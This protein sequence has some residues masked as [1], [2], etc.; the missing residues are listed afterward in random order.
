M[1]PRT[2]VPKGAKLE[3]AQSAAGRTSTALDTRT[4]VPADLPV[5]QLDGRS[6]IP[7]HVPLDVLGKRTVVPRDMPLGPLDATSALPQHLP[8]TVLDSRVVVPKGA[9]PPAIAPLQPRAV[10]PIPELFEPDILTTGKINLMP[11]PIE[12]A[13]V[14]LRWAAKISSPLFHAMLIWLLMM[15]PQLFAPRAP[16]QRDIELAHRSLGLV[17]LPPAVTEVPRV[18]P[19]PTESPSGK[20]RIDPRLLRQLIEPEREPS[21]MPG[22]AQPPSTH[23]QRELPAAPTPQPPRGDEQERQRQR[24]QAKLESPQGPP[25]PGQIVLPPTSPGRALE[26]SLRGSLRGRGPRG[27]EFGGPV[28]PSPG[29]GGGQGYLGGAVQMLTPDEGVDFS[30]YLARVLA[31]VRRNWYAVIPESARLGEK[32][33]VVIQFKILKDGSVP[34]AEPALVMTS[35]RDPLDRAAMASIRASNPFEPLPPAFN[36]AYI[37]LRFIFLYNLPLDYQ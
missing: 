18:P 19:S 22:P 17:Y 15:W 1:I 16:T 26:E 28:P 3:A 2:L 14:H 5:V 10:Q 13:G 35:G 24:E 37:E 4:L 34:Q 9:Q 21:P 6:N 12:S 20:M 30:N 25:Q 7:A 11:R 8:L 27:G 23:A 36:G 31:S 29:G 32:G 33:R